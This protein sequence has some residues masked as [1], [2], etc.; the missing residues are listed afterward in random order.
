[1][2]A[3]GPREILHVRC[4]PDT[5]EALYRMVLDLLRD[6]TPAVQALPPSAALAD[7]TG[8]LRYWSRTPLEMA[9]R[10]RLQALARYDVD[11]SIGVAGTCALA[12]TASARP[13]H[14]G[15]TVVGHGGEAVS[16]FLAPL[17]VRA[18]EGVE[19]AQAEQLAHYGL[20]TVGALAAMPLSTVQRILGGRAGRLVHERAHG[21]DPRPVTPSEP[22]H[23]L[24][25][26]HDFDRDTLDAATVRAAL[27]TI[28]VGLGDTLRD[29]RQAARA[30]TLTVTFADRSRLIRS[31]TLPEASAHTEDLR[32][33]AYRAFDSLGLQRARVRGVTLRAERLAPARDTGR[34]ISLD[35]ARENRLRA[36]PAVDRANRRF[37]PGTVI[38]ASL[39]PPRRAG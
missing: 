6:V 22:P 21:V 7:V 32:L 35:R 31:R 2:D 26:H 37:G 28:V 30:L 4:R 27:L 1:M 19:P 15:V 14:G 9:R 16:A 18:L 24:A 10:I 11:T 39:T 29:R 23:S 13:S 5:E 17:P 3:S 25:G 33:A 34:Q 38:P 36:E 20:H 12:A 8:S